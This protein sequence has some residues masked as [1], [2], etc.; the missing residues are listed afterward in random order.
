MPKL[1][2]AAASVFAAFTA[3]A[4]TATSTSLK[5]TYLFTEQGVAGSSN[6]TSLG[7]FTLDD[8]GVVSGSAY[9]QSAGRLVS[10]E[11][12]GSYTASATAAG[13]LSLSLTDR[14]A[15][16]DA[17]PALENIE[18]LSTSKEISGLRLD[19]GVN[20]AVKLVPVVAKP[21]LAGSFVMA[22]QGMLTNG[23]SYLMLGLLKVDASGAVAGTATLDISAQPVDYTVS[24]TATSGTDGL[25]SLA[26]TLS[27]SDGNPVL[28][29][30]YRFA[31][32]SD[33]EARAI[34]VDPGPVAS[35]TLEAR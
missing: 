6:F 17:V 4:Q 31:S 14:D 29:A 2:L 18:F 8:S 26:L 23:Q 33:K 32:I 34:R 7:V 11:V 3:S 9:L 24:G 28:N 35:V 27:D 21:S 30:N 12:S 13:K 25:G 22:E 10:A 16:D 1:T 15:G 5:G 19:S 20:S